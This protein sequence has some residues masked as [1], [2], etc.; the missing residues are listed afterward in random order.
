MFGPGDDE[1]DDEDSSSGYDDRT[2]DEK[3][4][5]Y[6]AQFVEDEYY[7]EDPNQC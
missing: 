7:K 6:E 4:S 1:E 2:E 3:E 5:D